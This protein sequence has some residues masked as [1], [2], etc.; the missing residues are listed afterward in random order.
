[1]GVADITLS[2]AITQQ[3]NQQELSIANLE[4][5]VSSGRSLNKPSDNPAAVT[6]V[7]QLSSQA[8]QL[9]SWQANAQTAT[10]WLGM[11]NNALNSALND[12][13]SARTLILQALNQ[14][15]QDATTYQAAAQQLQGINADLLSTA[16]TQY[17]GR[18][19]F[20]GTSASSQAYDAAGNYLGNNDTPNVVIGS[21]PG[22]GQTASL[23]VPGPSV[24]GTG[25]ASVF[26]TLTTVAGHTA[27]DANISTAEQASAVLGN[28]SVQVAAV[29]AS[30]TT[31]L[32]SVQ[33]TQAGLEDVNVAT[34]TTQLD[35]EMTNYQAAMWAASQA[36]PE[37]LVHFL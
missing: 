37:T 21:G 35:S 33:N 12:M 3:L 30:L 31:Q 15:T 7:L 25:A 18:P 17:E 27:L 19:I 9:S 10:S 2:Q 11:G 24:F 22:S 29:S 13:Q 5:Q 36:I 32:T 28:G 23:S 20:A 16:N 14:G 8:G 6:Q 4:E 34:V 1:V 26:N